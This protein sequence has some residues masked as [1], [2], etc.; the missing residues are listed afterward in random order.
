MLTRKR[1]RDDP[2]ASFYEEHITAN[3]DVVADYV[4]NRGAL[5]NN[6]GPARVVRTSTGVKES[7]ANKVHGSERGA[8]I[9][10]PCIV[11][12]GYSEQHF[13]G[14]PPFV[15]KLIHGTPHQYSVTSGY[16]FCT[17][18]ALNAPCTHPAVSSAL[19]TRNARAVSQ[20]EPVRRLVAERLIPVLVDIV[21]GYLIELP[22]PE[23]S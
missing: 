13:S 16:G 8:A 9:D 7:F 23:V 11:H 4:D 5:H 6:D 17:L 10:K 1:F 19:L 20:H 15:T 22:F 18:V 21:M 2:E 14:E 3:G 12:C